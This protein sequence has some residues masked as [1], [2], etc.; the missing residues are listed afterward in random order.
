MRLCIDIEAVRV[1]LDGG[2][3]VDVERLMWTH[4]VDAQQELANEQDGEYTSAELVRRH[5][6]KQF[7]GFGGFGVRGRDGTEDRI[8]EFPGDLERVVGSLTETEVVKIQE[9][10]QNTVEEA[11]AAIGNLSKSDSA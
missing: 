2:A 3:W 10:T 11:D 6:M 5:L 4:R 9:E 1:E 7:T 8:A